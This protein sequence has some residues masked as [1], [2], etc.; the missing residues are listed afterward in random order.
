MRTLAVA[1]FIFVLELASPAGGGHSDIQFLTTCPAS[2]GDTVE[3][4]KN[5]YGLTFDPLKLEHVTPNK[6]VFQYHFERYGVFL[7]FDDH[8]TVTG[9]RFDKPFQGKINGVA[10][11]DTSDRLRSIKGEP[12]RE[13]RGAPIMPLTVGPFRYATA[14]VYNP[15]T[16]DFV[17]YDIDP[18]DNRVSSIFI[19]SCSPGIA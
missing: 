11:G 18:A 17:R 12:D 7:F 1:I 5:F 3:L 16:S 14:W 13:F 8:Q 6:T 4:V 10:I 2:K 9:M 19:S 15:G